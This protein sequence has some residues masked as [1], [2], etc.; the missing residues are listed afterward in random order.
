MRVDLE[1][2]SQHSGLRPDTSS[3]VEVYQ[4]PQGICGILR[5]GK[6]NKLC[7]ISFYSGADLGISRGVRRIFEKK[8]LFDLFSGRP[9]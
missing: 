8:I 5:N 3:L 7:C 2:Q 6:Q 9:N 1:R 4:G